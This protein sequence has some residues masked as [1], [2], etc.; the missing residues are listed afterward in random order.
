MSSIFTRS[1]VTFPF[2]LENRKLKSFSNGEEKIRIEQ[3]WAVKSADANSFI[4]SL[5]NSLD[6]LALANTSV[7]NRGGLAIVSVTYGDENFSEADTIVWYS[8]SSGVVS[9]HIR[10]R[11]KNDPQS[12]LG[13]C[14]MCKTNY[15]YSPKEVSVSCNPE[16][17]EEYTFCEATFTPQNQVIDEEDDF[18]PSEPEEGEEEEET[19]TEEGTS[20]QMTSTTVVIP[21]PVRAYINNV[22][23]KNQADG[24]IAFTSRVES[25]EVRW[26]E[27]GEFGNNVP[28][29]SGWMNTT[30]T[31]N[32]LHAE[33]SVYS[34]NEYPRDT[35]DKCIAAMKSIPS[36]TVQQMRVTITSKVTK[37]QK[38]SLSEMTSKLNKAGEKSESISSGGISMPAPQIKEVTAGGYTFKAKTSWIYEGG[39]FDISNLS[40]KKSLSGRTFY[41]GTKTE[42]W[43]SFTEIEDAGPDDEAGS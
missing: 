1:D 16:F 4:E 40:A 36:A 2:C 7:E 32:P 39:S 19:P 38:M 43:S 21:V 24:L 22:V 14:T 15:G 23:G 25:G 26:V 35:V 13:F 27:Q 10:Q 37:S 6:N 12:I 5:G 42:S 20:C 3:K 30:G 18:T 31:I 34:T 8:M 17:G 28:S 33:P 9:M 41:V 11:V 29:K